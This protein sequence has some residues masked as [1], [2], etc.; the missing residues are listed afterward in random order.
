M[1]PLFFG[2]FPASVKIPA[3][4]TSDLI[5]LPISSFSS[6]INVM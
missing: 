1:L 5:F 6:Y 3:I 2:Y 4:Q